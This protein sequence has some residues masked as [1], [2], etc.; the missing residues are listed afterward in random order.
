MIL[1]QF[2]PS[3]VLV[4]WWGLSFECP[5]ILTC[6]SQSSWMPLL[7]PLPSPWCLYCLSCPCLSSI[8]VGVQAS[9]KIAAARRIRF[10][11]I[12]WVLCVRSTTSSSTTTTHTIRHDVD[13]RDREVKQQTL[14][15]A[16]RCGCN[17]YPLVFIWL[18][19]RYVVGAV[20]GAVPWTASLQR[21]QQQQYWTTALD[22]TGS[23]LLV[24][25]PESFH[26]VKTGFFIYQETR[27]NLSYSLRSWFQVLIRHS[28]ITM[29]IHFRE[30]DKGW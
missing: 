13:E 10:K 26:F 9:P 14:G 28:L 4:R 1:T 23:S 17:W 11:P 22:R 24:Q 21:Q 16:W 27:L 30:D 15:T 6:Q 29:L 18:S 5:S 3:K 2:H 12:H 8:K 7:S 25:K 20:V 19:A